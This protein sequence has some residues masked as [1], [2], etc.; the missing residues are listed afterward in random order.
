MI[1]LIR[2]EKY[3]VTRDEICWGGGHSKAQKTEHNC[4]AKQLNC[5]NL[6]NKDSHKIT[7]NEIASGSVELAIN[8]GIV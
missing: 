4:K 8:G 6:K 3:Y 1:K 2:S 7:E 5:V